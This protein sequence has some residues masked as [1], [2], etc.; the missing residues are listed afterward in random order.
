VL[1]SDTG[2]STWGSRKGAGWNAKGPKDQ[3]RGPNR[4]RDEAMRVD[5]PKES[6]EATGGV[7]ATAKATTA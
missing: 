6:V 3:M 7:K 2:R 4:V 5:I 1:G